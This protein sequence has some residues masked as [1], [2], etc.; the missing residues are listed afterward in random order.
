MI[1]SPENV[2]STANSLLWP[3]GLSIHHDRAW[4]GKMSATAQLPAVNVA[5]A[6][7]VV[8]GQPVAKLDKRLSPL[9]SSS[10]KGR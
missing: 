6:N 2:S 4:K 7:E 3:F 5:A 10:A 9:R 8:G 1:D